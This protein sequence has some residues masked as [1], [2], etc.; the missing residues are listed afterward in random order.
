M[1]ARVYSVT[2]NRAMSAERTMV[3]HIV[4]QP[5][6]AKGKR[7]IVDVRSHRPDRRMREVPDCRWEEKGS[8]VLPGLPVGTKWASG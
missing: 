7:T 4:L 8:C 1:A 2:V 6:G 3:E 5:E